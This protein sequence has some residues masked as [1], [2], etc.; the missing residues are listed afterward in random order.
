MVNI[1]GM[2]AYI[3]IP[4]DVVVAVDDDHGIGRDGGIPWRVPGD[5]RFFKDLT[6]RASPGRRNAVVMGRKTWES[7]PARFRPLPG[8][9]NV[10]LSRTACYAPDGAV[11]ASGLSEALLLTAELNDVEHVFIIGGASVYAEAMSRPEFRCAWVSRIPGSYGCDV[12]LAAPWTPVV[13][14]VCIGDGFTV[15]R[16]SR[17]CMRPAGPGVA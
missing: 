9:L 15:E 8:R 14:T 6:S 7:I 4:I 1:I 13:E 5:V 11:V 10:V 2:V 3:N 17:P 16:W 12:R